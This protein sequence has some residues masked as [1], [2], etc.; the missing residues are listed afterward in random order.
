MA[1]GA[2]QASQLIAASALMMAGVITALVAANVAKRV[3]GALIGFFGAAVA[4]AALGAPEGAVVAAIAMAFGY[5]ALGVALLV[6][7]QEGYGASETPAFDAA[8]ADT[9]PSEPAG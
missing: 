7:L 2:L 8:D 4:L 6:R 5:G 3:V 9:E 1:T